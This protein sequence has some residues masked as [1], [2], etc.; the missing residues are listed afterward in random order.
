LS[1]IDILNAVVDDYYSTCPCIDTNQ[2][3]TE[4]YREEDKKTNKYRN[5]LD[6]LLDL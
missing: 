4:T 2:E 3:S 6:F 1:N 5:R